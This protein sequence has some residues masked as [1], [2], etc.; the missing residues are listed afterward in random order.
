MIVPLGQQIIDPMS[1]IEVIEKKENFIKK[2]EGI[3]KFCIKVGYDARMEYLL[4]VGQ[5][6]YKLLRYVEVSEYPWR[7]ICL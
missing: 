2:S 6:C 4:S 7:Q 5:D 3:V 1:L